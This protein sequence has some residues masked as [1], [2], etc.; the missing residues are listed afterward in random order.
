MLSSPDLTGEFTSAGT[1][2]L[3]K[4]STVK[5]STVNSSLPRRRLTYIQLKYANSTIDEDV[6][7]SGIDFNVA[8]LNEKGIPDRSQTT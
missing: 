4:D 6:V 5:V 3:T 2:T 7:L 1:F 8:L